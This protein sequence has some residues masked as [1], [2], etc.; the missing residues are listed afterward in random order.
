MK[1]TII[2]G[3]LLCS[4]V[5]LAAG[6]YIVVAIESGK[7]RVDE[8][9]RLHQVEILREHYLI[10]IKRV[11]SDLALRNTRHSRDFD[12]VVMDVVTMGRA[13]NTCF[14]CHHSPA[15]TALLRELKTETE[16]YEDALSRVFTIRANAAR[17]AEEEE[18]AFREGEELSVR[19]KDMIAMTG[20]KL[21]EKTRRSL[22]EIAELRYLLYVLLGISPLLAA[23][24]AYAFARGFT[25][26]FNALLEATRKLKGG[27]LGYRVAGLK[28]EFGELASS[29]N[30]MAGSLQEQMQKMQRT[31]QMVVLAELAAGLA[32]EIKNPLAGIKVAMDVLAREAHLSAEDRDVLGK[33]TAEVGRLETLMRSFLNFA[34]PSKPLFSAVNVNNLLN[35]TLTFYLKHR[36][37]GGTGKD[38]IRI[39]KNLPPLPST[40]AD[41]MQLQQ[42]FLNLFLNAIDAMP[43]G[44]VLGIRTA[45]DGSPDEIRIEIS[46]TGRGID[47]EIAGR[48]FQP[49]FTTK[50]KGTGLG[51]PMSKL[52]IEQQGGSIGVAGNPGGGT[53]FTLRLPVRPPG[54]EAAP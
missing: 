20:G 14:D 40:S 18:N 4:A 45:C 38:G 5:F 27:D 1:K 16:R 23:S 11:Q 28:D 37:L 24:L 29:F 48:I 39:E 12:T 49:F 35:T 8:L 22:V 32:H 3:L 41:P 13:V 36:S 54:E 34:K 10:Q 17:R 7:S 50:A 19:V 52:L 15:A 31:E 46:D 2:V 44:G 25:G 51:L 43:E 21:G 6:I 30:E 9:V 42:V 47:P 26:S 33:V 53:V